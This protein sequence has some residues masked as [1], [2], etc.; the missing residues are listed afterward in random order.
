MNNRT[1]F[2]LTMTLFTAGCAG[3]AAVGDWEGKDTVAGERNTLELDE[4]GR[5]QAEI[6]FY[7]NGD[8]YRAEFDVEWEEKD[9]QVVLELECEGDC[10]DL[11]FDMECDVESDGEELDCEADGAFSDYDFEWERD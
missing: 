11:D 1:L 3:P 9:D 7:F 6:F 8:A 5:G 10:A 2:A 4:D